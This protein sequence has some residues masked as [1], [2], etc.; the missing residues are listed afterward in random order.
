MQHP[1]EGTIHALLDGQLPAE[2]AAAL[3]AHAAECSECS[4]IIAEA[5]GLIAASSR[6]VS[7]LDAVPSGVIPIRKTVKRPWYAST[8]LRAAAAVL[9]VAGASMLVLRDR[10][11]TSVE[12]SAAR[13]ADTARVDAAQTLQQQPAAEVTG[14]ARADGSAATP[15]VAVPPAPPARS[16]AA[17]PVA[18]AR[19]AAGPPSMR[20]DARNEA[21]SEIRRTAPTSISVGAAANAESD[22]SKRTAFAQSIRVDPVVVTGVAADQVA[23][24][25]LKLVRRDSTDSTRVTVYEVS[26]G[27][28]VTLSERGPR[29]A[30]VATAMRQG[31]LRAAQSGAPTEKAMIAAQA[32]PQP[33]AAAVKPAPIMSIN[34]TDSTTRRVYILSGPVSA[35]KLE[36]IRALIE[37]SKP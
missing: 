14:V 9:F 22:A 3:E 32:P 27:V 34:W 16:T 17:A 1:D 18:A 33:A 4:A 29:E 30:S 21:S 8:Q 12:D 11:L 26:P 37:R 23:V 2:E 5:R 7:A 24:E 10:D 25:E 19:E 28:E 13:L 6:I 35:A 36:Q 31:R 20:D 15:Q